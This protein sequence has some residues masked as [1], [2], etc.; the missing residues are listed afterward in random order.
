MF[1]RILITGS[2]GFIGYHLSLKLIELGFNIVGIDNLNSYYDINLKNA[3]LSRLKEAA[4]KHKDILADFIKV[5]LVDKNLIDEV[6]NHYKPDVVVHLAAQAGVRYSLTNPAE[7]INSNLLGFGNILENLRRVKVKNFIYASSSSVYGG[8]KKVPFSEKD[9][10][11]HPISLYAATKKSN[12][13]MAHSYSHLYGIPSTAL[14]L[15]TVYGPWGRPDMAPMIFTKSIFS[16]NPIDIFNFGNMKRDFTYIDDVILTIIELINKPATSDIQFNRDNPNPSTSWACH[17]I[18]NLG[19]N[20]PIEL[21]TFINLLEN[22][23]GKKAN[24]NFVA[25][26]PGDIQETYSDNELVYEWSGYKERTTINKGIRNF[27]D[28]YKEFYKIV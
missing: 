16:G 19:S 23:I 9:P 18:F 22:E 14:R 28:W 27:I 4:S 20:N 5:D 15:F 1:H 7:Y 10:V 2:A 13:L 6:F 17:R 26:Q 3:R 8:N 21:N 25:M 24:K 11:N 12:E